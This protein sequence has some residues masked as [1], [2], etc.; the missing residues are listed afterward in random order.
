MTRA[1]TSP[2]GLRGR[3]RSPTT[4]TTVVCP[5]VATTCRMRVTRSGGSSRSLRSPSRR[6]FADDDEGYPPSAAASPISFTVVR[7]V[8]DR[9]LQ[10]R[11]GRLLKKRRPVGA[12][13]LPAFATRPSVPHLVRQ[14]ML[15]PVTSRDSPSASGSTPSFSAA[16][17]RRSGL[18]ARF[19]GHIRHQRSAPPAPP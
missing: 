2:R 16:S 12:M 11:H 1:L 14:A 15:G 18:A 19:S 4:T 13:N 7:Q 3:Q 5:P 6:G 9:L 17:R 8:G 10:R